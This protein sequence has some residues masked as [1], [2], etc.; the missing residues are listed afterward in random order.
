M[1]L[2]TKPTGLDLTDHMYEYSIHSLFNKDWLS[3]P[4]IDL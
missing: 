4:I 3:K 1:A 2:H